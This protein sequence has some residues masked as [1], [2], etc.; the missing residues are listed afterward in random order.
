M[1]ESLG[2]SDRTARFYFYTFCSRFNRS[3]D[4]A[5]RLE[6][7]YEKVSPAAKPGSCKFKG[8]FFEDELPIRPLV[9]T[10]AGCCTKHPAARVSRKLPFSRFVIPEPGIRTIREK[11]CKNGIFSLLSIAGC[12]TLIRGIWVDNAVQLKLATRLDKRKGPSPKRHQSWKPFTRKVLSYFCVPIADP[13]PVLIVQSG[14]CG[15][16]PLMRKHASSND[17]SNNLN[18]SAS[19][20]TSVHRAAATRLCLTMGFLGHGVS[21]SREISSTILV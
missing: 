7:M 1:G 14:L 20:A 21:I 2:A 13:L 19:F 6:S 4:G 18:M 17:S 8:R 15:L 16:A 12:D 9:K 11:N 3:T 10:H 5:V